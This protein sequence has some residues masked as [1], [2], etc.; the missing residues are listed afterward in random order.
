MSDSTVERFRRTSHLSEGNAAYIEGLYETYLH[1]PNAVS[2]QWR[3]YFD[4]LPRVD[5]V[6]TPDIS[7]DTVRAHFELIGR[8][9]ARP[10]PAPGSGGVNVEHERKQVRVLELI[11]SYR[12]RGHQKAHLDPLGLMERD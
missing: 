6:V 4:A 8:R 10:V 5:G 9:Q 12:E 3:A 2:E 7:H 11:S 1:D